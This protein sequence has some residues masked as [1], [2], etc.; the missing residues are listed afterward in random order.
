VVKPKTREELMSKITNT[1]DLREMLLD[2]INKL[3]QG[4]GDPTVSRSISILAGKIIASARLD[5][6]VQ[7]YYGKNN[8]DA[9]QNNDK[10]LKLVNKN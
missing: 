8:P 5:L 3:R 4:D 6:E 10:V 2:E 1:E 9:L 7:K